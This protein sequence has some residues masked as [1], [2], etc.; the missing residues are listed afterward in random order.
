MKL[1]INQPLHWATTFNPGASDD[2]L[3]DIREDYRAIGESLRRL[4]VNATCIVMESGVSLDIYVQKVTLEEQDM[5]DLFFNVLN[6]LFELEVR[7]AALGGQ[8]CDFAMT[9]VRAT[10]VNT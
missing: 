1:L 5:N 2:E 8:G 7:Y 10:P 6:V 9:L 3:E 4:G